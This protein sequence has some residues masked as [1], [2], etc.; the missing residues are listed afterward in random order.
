MCYNLITFNELFKM[1]RIRPD[2]ILIARPRLH[3]MQRG[4]KT[5]SIKNPKKAIRYCSYNSVI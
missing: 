2:R 5:L 4:K 3:S 1:I